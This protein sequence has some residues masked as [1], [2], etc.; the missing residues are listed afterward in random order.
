MNV[1]RFFPKHN[2]IVF[3]N[4]NGKGYGD[5]PQ[6]IA[7]E[8]I[9]QG[10]PYDLVWLTKDMGYTFPR[11]VRK[12]Q[13]DSFRAIFELSTAKIIVNNVK[14]GLPYVKCKNQYYIQTWHGGFPLKF[15]EKECEHFLNPKYVAN[16]KADSAIT[17]LFLSCCSLD[18]AIVKQSFWYTGE[19]FKEGIP[20]N[21]IFFRNNKALISETKR[22]LGIKED[23]KIVLYAPTFRDNNSTDA[24]SLEPDSVIKPLEKTTQVN[25]VLIIRLHPNVRNTAIFQYSDNVINGSYISDPQ[26]L[27]VISDILITDY[28]SIM[29]DFS[30]MKKPVFLYVTDLEN[31]INTRGLR[32][33]FFNLPYIM[34][35]NNQELERAL[36]RVDQTDYIEKIE[37]FYK[38]TIKRW[39]DGKASEKIVKRI[40]QRIEGN[41]IDR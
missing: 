10:L 6:Y 40:K 29:Y 41:N 25:W 38:N 34:C 17:D 4:F 22:K 16:S 28:S 31:Y 7:E 5:N 2:K 19:V 37:L 14:N 18:S 11:Q 1:L 39:D 8:I 30:L 32:P 27:V 20:R 23:V 9:R 12:V 15:I 33:L 35:R 36:Q 26:H 13:F 21:D 24:Y 3:S